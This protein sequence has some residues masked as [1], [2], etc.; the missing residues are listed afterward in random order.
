MATL[1]PVISD[2]GILG[3]DYSDILQQIKI[4]YFSIYGS[5]AVLDDDSQD[6][7]FVAA[8]IA[9]PIFDCGSAA[10]DVYNSFSPLSARGTGLSSLVKLNGLRRLVATNS[11]CVVTLT[12][13]VGKSIVNGLIG[14]NQNLNTQWSLPP[15][16]IIGLD[17]T[18][19]VTATATTAGATSAAANT[20]TSILTPTLGWQTV[21]NGANVASPGLPVEQDTV[22]RARQAK[23]TALP[24]MTVLEG[25]F[26]AV[27]AIN[28]VT[29][30]AT[31]QNDE[32]VADGNG[33]PPHSMAV[34]VQGG[35]V[36][37]VAG[38]IALKKAPGTKTNG[39]TSVLVT[40][41][42]GVPNLIRF[43]ELTQVVLTMI[44]TIHP[45]IGYVSTTGDTLKQAVADFVNNTL[46]I[47]ED[48]YRSRLFTPANLTSPGLGDTFVVTDIKQARDAGMPGEGDIVI[49]FIETATLIVS[50]I[51]LVLV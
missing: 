40:D 13:T 43:Y 14:D 51:T 10:I 34:V 46:S 9:Q 11:Q 22:L 39:T 15:L 20:L 7:Q 23:S 25:I 36:N 17:G 5:D 12:G 16:V 2:T 33:M 37:L 27:E 45:L 42:K 47:G 18:V 41:N 48:S 1:A 24:A 49:S 6:G 21:T 38:A 28:G 50:N 35:D 32:D 31:Y 26:A 29:D 30:L 4:V 44:I 3:S 8:A 19:T